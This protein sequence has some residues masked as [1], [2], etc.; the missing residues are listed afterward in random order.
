MSDEKLSVMRA[1]KTSK[2]LRG[3]RKSDSDSGAFDMANGG[4]PDAG[5][6]NFYIDGGPALRDRND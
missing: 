2:F 5:G 6:L 4:P 1:A 3:K